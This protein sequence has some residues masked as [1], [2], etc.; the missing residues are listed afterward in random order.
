MRADELRDTLWDQCDD[1]RQEA[2]AERAAIVADSFIADH[3][4][5][6]SA[7]FNA[8][9][10]IE[11]DRVSGSAAVVVDYVLNSSGNAV[12]ENAFTPPDASDATQALL[13]SPPEWLGKVAERAPA[14][15][16]GLAKLVASAEAVGSAEVAQAEG[17]E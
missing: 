17:G 7:L 14:L 16:P 6:L 2:E 3:R 5:S 10:E 12:P 1:R 11:A 4:E 13:D 8:L 15:A 9:A